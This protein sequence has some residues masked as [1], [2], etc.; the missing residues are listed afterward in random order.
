MI[1]AGTHPSINIDLGG[2]AP[3]MTLQSRLNGTDNLTP[4]NG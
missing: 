3:G 4:E 2:N 1:E